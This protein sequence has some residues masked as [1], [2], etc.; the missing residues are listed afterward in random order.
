M[1]KQVGIYMIK[2]MKDILYEINPIIKIIIVI[3]ITITATLDRNPYFSV[4]LFF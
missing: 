3:L 2:K 4:F 1:E